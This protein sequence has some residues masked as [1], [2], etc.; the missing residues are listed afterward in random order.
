MDA[1]KT[2]TIF[3]KESA[4]LPDSLRFESELCS[5]GWREVKNLD[6]YGL[7]GKIRE[8]GWTFFYMAGEIRVSVFGFERARAASQ[9]VE[10]IMAKLKLDKFNS[11]EITRVTPKRFLGLPYVT[12][13]AHARHIQQ[14]IFLFRGQRQLVEPAGTQLAAA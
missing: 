12:L 7:G 6:G 8:A 9:A 14:S 11:L 2:G 4:L 1:I 3:I 5:N 10:R 13:S